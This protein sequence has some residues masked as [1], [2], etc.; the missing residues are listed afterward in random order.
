MTWVDALRDATRR[1]RDLLRL[2]IGGRWVLFLAADAVLI[3]AG[4]FDALL[5]EGDSTSQAYFTVVV[6]PALLLGVPALSDLVALERDAGSLDL[7]LATPDAAHHLRARFFAVAGLMLAQA[8]LVLLATW[9]ATDFAFAVVPALV[10]SAATF[11][12]VGAAALFWATRLESSGAVG[13]ATFA[14]ALALGRWLL[15]APLAPR[16]ATGGNAYLPGFE[17]LLATTAGSLVLAA[18]A[19]GLWLAARRR[20]ARTALLLR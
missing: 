18:S 17:F 12:L 15:E 3:V 16:T 6:A 20:L 14:T 2:Q 5:G 11:A 10:H 4:V 19:L 7:L 1:W 8:W 13:M 9:A